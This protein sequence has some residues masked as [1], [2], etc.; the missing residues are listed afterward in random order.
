METTMFSSAGGQSDDSTFVN[1][2]ACL[3]I[4]FRCKNCKNLVVNTL[5]Q[6]T[7]RSVQ[8]RI[9]GRKSSNL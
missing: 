2:P 4:N 3:K 1:L 7:G 8:L 5:G 6:T 9:L